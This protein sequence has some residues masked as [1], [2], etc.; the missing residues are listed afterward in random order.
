M[1]IDNKSKQGDLTQ[2]KQRKKGRKRRI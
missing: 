1:K 2:R